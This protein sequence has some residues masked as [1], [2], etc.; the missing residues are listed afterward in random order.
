MKSENT[1]NITIL[2]VDDMELNLQLILD[3]LH[4]TPY[5]FH[6]ARDGVEAWQ[7]LI[8]NHNTYSAVLLDRVMPKLDGMAVLKM[9]K[10]HED[11]KQIPVIFQTSM[12]KEKNIIEGIQAGAYH[13]L[14][15]PFKKK[16]LKAILKSAISEYTQH[17]TLNKQ[18][19]EITNA[20]TFLKSGSFQFRTLEE[21][22]KV[23]TLMSNIGPGLDS[24][25]V[26]IWEL[27]ANA[28]EHGNLGIKYEEKSVLNENDQWE[29]EVRRRLMLPENAD[30]KVTLE[31]K[32]N[33]RAVQ[34]T[35]QD[36]GSGFDWESYMDFCPDRVFDNHGRGIA[37]ANNFSFDSLTYKGNGNRV[38]ATVK[39][40]AKKA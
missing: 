4:D 34:F 37:M 19:A 35:I 5:T 9:M 8:R 26:G 3:Y 7:L 27:I 23:S 30:K 40:P 33:V 10:S 1:S 22:R 18:A 13:Y 12:T 15:K 25:V 32:R 24:A 2:I 11:L 16:I 14:A 38:V 17:I 28:V 36:Q 39:C 21:G 6:T 20:V 29:N 31:V